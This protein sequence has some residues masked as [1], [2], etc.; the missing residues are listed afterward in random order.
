MTQIKQLLWVTTVVVGFISLPVAEG[1]TQAL[2]SS[3]KDGAAAPD[4]DARARQAEE[5]FLRA[6]QAAQQ[7]RL[8]QKERILRY[9]LRQQEREAKESA[10][11]HFLLGSNDVPLP[12]RVAQIDRAFAQQRAQVAHA[13]AQERAQQHAALTLERDLA[14]QPE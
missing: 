9:H 13:L 8:A 12:D 3:K 4:Y 7:Q 10:E 14:R 5:R 11:R 2:A 6:Q 1:H